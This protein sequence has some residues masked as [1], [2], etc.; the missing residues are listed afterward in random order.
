MIRLASKWLLRLTL[1]E[2][3]RCRVR[4]WIKGTLQFALYQFR[5]W[6]GMNL[7]KVATTRFDLLLHGFSKGVSVGWLGKSSNQIYSNAFDYIQ[8]HFPEKKV[9]VLAKEGLAAWI[10]ET[11]KDKNIVASENWNAESSLCVLLYTLIVLNNFN[12]IIETGVANGVTTRVMMRALERTGGTLHSFDILEES[13]NVY[14]GHGSWVFHK[15]EPNRGIQKQLRHEVGS[16][17]DCDMWVHDSNHGQTW[18]EFE[19]AL[20]WSNLRDKGVLLSDDVDASPAWGFASAKYLNKPAVIFDIRKFI[21][22][23]F[24]N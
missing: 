12:K 24:K 22:V 10:D 21:G 5:D 8:N 6:P 1:G 2:V 11:S 9:D 4:R 14:K 23:S 15:L 17:G 16:I 13:K 7:H 19:Y 20:A 18:Q 3:H